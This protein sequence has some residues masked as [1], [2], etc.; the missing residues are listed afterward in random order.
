MARD[1]EKPAAC[2]LRVRQG[3]SW[4]TLVRLP[5]LRITVLEGPEAGSQRDFTLQTVRIGSAAEN[6]LVLRDATVSRRHARLVL[7]P[8]GW[9][10]IDEGSRNGTVVDG[11]RVREAYLKEG[12]RLRLGACVLELWAR[13]EDRFDV[14]GE[15]DRMGRLCGGSETMR[16]VYSLVRAIAPTS[17]SALIQGESGTGK[18]LVARAIHELSGR[19][20]PLV[21]FDAA[22]TS[23]DLIRSELFG[24]AKGAFTGAAE[25]REGAFRR[26]HGGTLFID[27]FGELP[28]GL[29]PNLLRALE[30]REVTPVGSDRPFPV[31]VRVLAATNL[32]LRESIAAG[33]FREDLYQRVAVVTVELPALRQ[34]PEDIPLLVRHFMQELGSDF[35]LGTE[36]LDRM[37]RHDWPGNVRELRNAIERLGIVCRGREVLPRDF[38]PPTRSQAVSAGDAAPSAGLPG[39]PGE[40]PTLEET[41]RA[42][43]LAALERTGGNKMAAARLLGIAVTTLKRKL[44]AGP[45]DS[46]GE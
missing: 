43:I 20:G 18:E 39:A 2:T 24:H 7:D 26:A 37:V 13:V 16:G 38:A 27:E 32:D 41:E 40:A 21:V 34:R 17:A 12:G 28:L 11:V 8:A 10:V 46:G 4:A 33:R 25:S 6:D 3:E 45:S 22:A 30:S 14:V 5:S 29:Q 19:A 44:A 1:E 35:E 36:M 15:E 23:P 31:D 42:A 9:L